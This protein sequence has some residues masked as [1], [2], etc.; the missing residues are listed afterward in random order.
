MSSRLL[1]NGHVGHFLS[2]VV[3]IFGTGFISDKT[4]ILDA[5]LR[6]NPKVF[7]TADWLSF[8]IRANGIV[9]LKAKLEF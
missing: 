8:L 3:D 7:I 9:R 6:I 2:A 1:T 4:F 5:E